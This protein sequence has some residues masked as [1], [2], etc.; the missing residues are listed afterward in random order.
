MQPKA[1]ALFVV[2][3][4]SRGEPGA[5][6]LVALGGR[7]EQR[8]KTAPLYRVL[9]RDTDKGPDV[10]LVRVLTGGVAV[11]GEV[12]SVPTE[13]F[14]ALLTGLAPFVTVGWMQLD[15]GVQALG[16][17]LEAA[18]AEA[19]EDVSEA[20]EGSWRQVLA[21]RAPTAM[22][23]N[24]LSSEKSSSHSRYSLNSSYV[25]EESSSPGEDE[26]SVDRTGHR[27]KP[28][29][30]SREGPRSGS[31]LHPLR[32]PTP[33]S[34]SAVALRT[35]MDRWSHLD[36]AQRDRLVRGEIPQSFIA[37]FWM[38]ISGADALFTAGTYDALCRTPSNRDVEDK[39]LKDI[40]R[41]FQNEEVTLD[42]DK[43]TRL[44]FVLKAYGVHDPKV[45]YCQVRP[46]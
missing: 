15:G 24:E 21:A 32:T 43:Q 1:L 9:L 6:Q 35:T 45:G 29:T 4:R 36:Q 25:F 13:S 10:A 27:V 20:T 22:A 16:L 5:S 18:A 41:T 37:D 2:G 23:P 12:W 33:E 7:F 30:R 3:A 28:R 34:L 8:V 31:P 38:Q 19:C 42:N 14:G 46:I 44:F 26:D 39:I 40:A 17:L 11:E